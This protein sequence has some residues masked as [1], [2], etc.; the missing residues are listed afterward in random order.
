M[1]VVIAIL[2]FP[3][4]E[5]L[6]FAGPLETLIVAGGVDG[7]ACFTVGPVRDIVTKPSRLRVV[8]DYTLDEAPRP[9]VVIVPGGTGASDEHPHTAAVVDYVRRAA[10]RGA[11]IASVCTGTFILGRA[12]LLDGR[13]CTTHVRYRE[14]LQREYPEAIVEPGTVVADGPSL[15]TAA[16]VSSGIDLSLYLLDRLYGEGSSER[17]AAELNFA[18][19][20][21]EIREY[22]AAA[23]S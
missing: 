2:V 8:A 13:H 20:P 3:D 11:L 23:R 1:K 4:V 18:P 22:D 9:D 15:V 17:M 14:R 10:E 21:E 5:L 7:G 19:R 6:D 16:N 12:G